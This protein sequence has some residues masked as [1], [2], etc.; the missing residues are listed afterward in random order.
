[1]LILDESHRAKAP[2]G[3][4]AEWL[5]KLART[6]P[7]R[8]G[9]TGTPM[10]HSPMDIFAQYRIIQPAI[11]GE[12]YHRFRDRYAVIANPPKN[13]RP[14]TPKQAHENHIVNFKNRDELAELFHSIAFEVRSDDVLELPPVN[15]LTYRVSL[16]PQTM[17]IYQDLNRSLKATLESGQ[18]IKTPNVLAQL[19]RLQQ[20]TSGFAATRGQ[21]PTKIDD[22][23]ADA[24]KDILTNLPID[25]PVV[26][27]ARF[28]HDLQTVREI[29]ES[30]GRNA[31]DLT[32]QQKQ[33]A[34][35]KANGGVLT[36]Q[37]QTGGTGLDLTN[38]RYCIY[39]SLGYNLGEFLQSQAR[40]HR[41]GQRHTVHQIHLIAAHTIDQKVMQSLIAKE[42]VIEAIITSHQP[43]VAAAA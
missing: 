8:L 38:A 15:R 36:A 20:L 33:L 39:Y 23:K 41:P 27:F 16:K 1:M 12:S 19:T 7:R 43:Q 40:L 18:T 32:G 37:I 3:V 5:A 21:S 42:D 29:A 2:T 4:T 34:E 30:T 11:F 10:P 14:G 35:W 31:W 9:L 24:V 26:V 13:P 25:E 17:A 28:L 6:I 22:A